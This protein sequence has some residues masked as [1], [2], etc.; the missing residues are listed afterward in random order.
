[1]RY[2][3]I[4]RTDMKVSAI[5]LGTA[6]MGASVDLKTTHQLL[7]RFVERGGN[8]LDS[9]HVYSDWVAGTKSVSEKTLGAW[10]KARG[11]RD[12]IIVATKG[13]H[14]RL[15]TMTKSRMT[16][17]D[18]ALDIREALEFLQ[19]DHIDL[20]YLHRDNPA[21]PV[22]EILGILNEQISK[23]SI[24]AIGCSNWREHRIAEAHAWA[25]EHALKS[26]VA[27]QN[28]WALAYADMGWMG[29]TTI[30]KTD[31]S[32]L[33]LCRTADIAAIPFSAQAGGFFT[34]KAAA[35]Q[36]RYD[37]TKKGTFESSLNYARL[38]AAV[39]IA[40]QLSVSV[41]AV[42]LAYLTCQPF[43][44][45]PVIGCKRIAQLDDSLGAADLVLTPKM[46]AELERGDE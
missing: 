16:R 18:I 15:E 31:E 43:C 1:M 7:D 23:G 37:P 33:H 40:G 44:A 17:E 28:L 32:I 5:C 26:F 20:F 21:M 30:L 42:A 27:V 41:T 38:R 14:P 10:M 25:Q 46:V 36:L 6:D 12:A 19:T 45:V 39:R 34:K 24:R 22:C 2:R 8:F 35:G 3:T 9:A 11:N 13:A 4:P 29:D